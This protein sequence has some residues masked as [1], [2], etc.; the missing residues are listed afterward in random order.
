VLSLGRVFHRHN[1]FPSAAHKV[2][3]TSHALY[4]LTRNDPICKRSFNADLKSAEDADVHLAATNHGER[5]RAREEASACDGCDRL[6]T[7]VDQI[8]VDFL[9]CREP[10]E[11]ENTVFALQ[12]DLDTWLHKVSAE[13]RDAD[14]QV[15]IHSIL[16]FLSSASNNAFASYLVF[17]L[18]G[19]L[20]RLPFHVKSTE[21]NSLLLLLRLHDSVNIN[22]GQVDLVGVK[23]AF[24]HDFFDFS[25]AHFAG[26]GD[27]GVEVAR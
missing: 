23:V 18:S 25:D 3:G 7:S 14:A 2:H 6:L 20:W 5:L 27:V 11:A 4:H 19:D 8:R 17:A 22:A 9:L 12:C 1:H 16:K 13:G 21:L 26:G 24:R 15:H 10:A